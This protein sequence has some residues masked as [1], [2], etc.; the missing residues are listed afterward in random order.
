MADKFVLIKGTSGHQFK[1]KLADLGAESL[2]GVA[3]AKSPF[4][5]EVV[6]PKG[7]A[8]KFILDLD[9]ADGGTFDLGIEGDLKTLN[10]DDNASTIETALRTI[11]GWD[12]VDVTLVDD[13]F[14][15]EF[16][17]TV[18]ESALQADFSS[19]TYTGEG[20]PDATLTMNQEFIASESEAI[21]LANPAVLGIIQ[22]AA[23]TAADLTFL[24][25]HE[26]Y[27]TYTMLKNSEGTEVKFTVA[28][29]QAS[30]EATLCAEL[31]PWP[32]I[33]LRSG[34]AATPVAQEAARTFVLVG[35]S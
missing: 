7:E 16:P 28:A 24:V 10:H 17:Y 11:S 34:A 32:F 1:V 6:I 15:I 13:V 2:Y 23:W 14:V 18:G 5:R 30:M 26:E 33:K 29:G 4:A 3:V 31:A 20:D 9:V 35:R 12:A 25:S 8:E 22:P 27:G 19:L 21:N